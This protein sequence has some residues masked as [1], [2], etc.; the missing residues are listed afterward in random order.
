MPTARILRLKIDMASPNI[1]LRDPA[2]YRIR[3]TGHH[4]T[5]NKWCVYPMY[6]YA[7]H[8][9]CAG[10][11]HAF[12]VHAG[13]RGAPSALRLGAGAPRRVRQAAST[14]PQQIEFAR[15][16]L[17]YTV[18]SKRKLPGWSRRA[19]SMA[20]TTRASGRSPGC[21]V[22]ALRPPQSACL[23]SGRVC[24]S[25]HQWIDMGDLGVRC[26]MTWMQWPRAAWRCSIRSAWS[27]RT[28]PKGNLRN[29]RRRYIR[30]TNLAAS[31]ASKFCRE[32]FH[33]A[34]RLRGEPGQGLL[35]TGASG[36][37][38]LRHA[39]II[40]CR[41][42]EKDAGQHRDDLRNAT[43]RRPRAAPVAAMSGAIHWVGKADGIQAGS[44]T[45]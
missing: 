7:L 44:A 12:A 23:P 29:A 18:M 25:T 42:I 31:A 27:S 19:M 43:T 33:R 34:R 10:A 15:L 6:D 22:V 40:K 3:H 1:N 26:V 41:R 14:K 24:R 39:F 35:P 4:R 11:H 21:V 45:L 32:V 9:R 8:Q 13:V 38:R 30:M 17:S 5:G 28:I 16:N 2:I 36:E 37:V 20:G